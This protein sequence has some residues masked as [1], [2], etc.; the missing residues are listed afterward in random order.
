M[1][2]PEPI[3]IFIVDFVKVRMDPRNREIALDSLMY[4][5][6]PELTEDDITK[7]DY[8][9]RYCCNGGGTSQIWMGAGSFVLSLADVDPNL[10]ME[11]GSMVWKNSDVV[12]VLKHQNGKIP[13]SYVSE[14]QRRH[15]F[16]FGPFSNTSK[17]SQILHDV[18][19]WSTIY[20]RVDSALGRRIRETSENI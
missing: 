5:K 13:L 14:T 17:I 15:A 4:G 1:H 16:R 19:P 7:Q 18:L 20:A 11:D 6:I 2:R 10:M 9:Y 8:I 12:V 3:A